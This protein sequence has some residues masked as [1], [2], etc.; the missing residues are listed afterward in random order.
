MHVSQVLV[1]ILHAKWK[2]KYNFFFSFLGP[3]LFLF[4]EFFSSTYFN[5]FFQVVVGF[6][7]FSNA[8]IRNSIDS[9]SLAIAKFVGSAEFL[10][11]CAFSV[12][13]V[14]LKLHFTDAFS[15]KFGALFRF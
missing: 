4:S 15:C 10:N 9:S 8:L 6:F 2:I 1:L 7:F 11:A 14:V 12:S 5:Y 3:S 13:S